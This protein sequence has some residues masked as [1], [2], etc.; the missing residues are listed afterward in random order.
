MNEA[1]PDGHGRVYGER[2]A[3][4]GAEVE[5]VAQGDL[6]GSAHEFNATVLK[7]PCTLAH[8]SRLTGFPLSIFERV[9]WWILVSAATV[10]KVNGTN[11]RAAKTNLPNTSALKVLRAAE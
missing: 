6:A 10:T 2:Y 4:A 8:F 7:I 5:V 9:L 3:A 11:A 1:P